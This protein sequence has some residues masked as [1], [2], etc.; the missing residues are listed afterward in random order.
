MVMVEQGDNKK[1]SVDLPVDDS[2]KEDN[3]DTNNV[4]EAKV[5]DFPDVITTQV[6]GDNNTE[7]NTKTPKFDPMFPI[8]SNFSPDSSPV[9]DG[10]EPKPF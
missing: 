8:E 1:E 10:K 2:N 5:S 6:E 7:N 9:K 3:K 4:E